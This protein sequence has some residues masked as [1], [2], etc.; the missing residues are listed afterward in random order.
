MF[1]GRRMNQETQRERGELYYYKAREKQQRKWR[2]IEGGEGMDVL[3]HCTVEEE[4]R[5][6]NKSK[7]KGRS[8]SNLVP[9]HK[10]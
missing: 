4:G 1:I 8:R 2:W 10:K 9:V 5:G 6:G 7:R 3:V